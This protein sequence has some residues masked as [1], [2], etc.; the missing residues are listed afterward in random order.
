MKT[1]RGTKV[2]MMMLAVLLVTTSCVPSSSKSS[3]P[4]SNTATV[5]S[6]D[7]SSS[8]T[9]NNQPAAAGTPQTGDVTYYGTPDPT[10]TLPGVAYNSCGVLY[11]QLNND[12]IFFLDNNGG[13]TL[14]V[15]QYSYDSASILNEVKAI[16]D[17]SSS[18]VSTCLEGYID[19]GIIYLNSATERTATD[20]PTRTNK[21]SYTYEYCGYI[22]HTTYSSN[23]WTLIKVGSK[24]YVVNNLSGSSW[25]ANIPTIGK[26]IS[27]E[28][29]LEACVY[30]NK[31]E[32]KDYTSSF[33][34][35]IDAA[36]IDLGALN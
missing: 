6:N 7:S 24:D 35:K 29:G 30:T 25:N 17:S 28:N 15:Q 19:S 21:S 3:R 10:P 1:I 27:S 12:N 33:Y 22:A 34:H 2:Y 32:Y 36:V 11:K 26:T 4:S 16:N 18:A 23:N 14:I 13:E 8:D 20:N 31:A 5:Q 9:N